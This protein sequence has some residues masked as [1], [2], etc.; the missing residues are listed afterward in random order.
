VA[1]RITATVIAMTLFGP[2]ALLSQTA[3]TPPA[4]KPAAPK[5]TTSNPATSKPATPKPAT[6]KPAAVATPPAGARA[7]ATAKE[8]TDALI[9][10]ASAFDEPALLAM[11]GPEGKDL[12]TTEDPIR[13]RSYALAFA[14]RAREAHSVV[15]RS[16]DPNRATIQ[17]G[18]EQWPLPVPLVRIGGKWYF[19]AK[20][21]RDEILFRRIG[22]N[23][24]DAIEICHGY[25]EAQN[26]YALDPHDDSGVRQYAQRVISTPGKQD[27]LYWQNAD[28]S[29]G[30]P[31][32]ET[33]AKAIEEG[34][35]VDAMSAYHGYLFH[36]LKGQGPAAP[37]GQMDYVIG[38]AM[39]GGFAL[40]ATPAEYGVTGVQT[41]IV[42]HNGIVY[43]KDL[44]PDSVNLAR[45]IDRYNPD[46]TWQR[47]TDGWSK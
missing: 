20:A 39:I 44:G 26:E 42:S 8:A 45:Q 6:A 18:S 28:G 13:D 47:T 5:P 43:Q 1:R 3:S 24:L 2:P 40:I 31:I 34:Y 14:A 4:A 22:A 38:G 11:F 12:V 10:A 35:A 41:F 46:K 21:G 19:D 23:E 36:V 15:V 7:F 29:P 16:S 9:A 32:S 27:G 37:M 33:V 25:V 17:V 30:G